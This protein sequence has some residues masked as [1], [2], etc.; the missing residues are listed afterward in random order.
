M[1]LTGITSSRIAISLNISRERVRQ[2]WIIY[3]TNNNSED[4]RICSRCDKEFIPTHKFQSTCGC[5]VSPFDSCVICGKTTQLFKRRRTYPIC[6][7]IECIDNL[8]TLKNQTRKLS[9][10][11][12]NRIKTEVICP[13]CNSSHLL[14]VWRALK[15]NFKMRCRSCIDGQKR[16]TC[17]VCEIPI[18]GLNG[19]CMRHHKRRAN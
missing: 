14:P 10:E 9:L 17:T 16:D 11:K 4:P 15:H 6:T 13:I 7:N 8:R 3:Q 2:L 18:S 19:R 5:S 1:K 12:R